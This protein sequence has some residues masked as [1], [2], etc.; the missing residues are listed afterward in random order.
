MSFEL[1]F[2][3]E[4]LPALSFR[5]HM[6]GFLLMKRFFPVYSV[7][8][9]VALAKWLCFLFAYIFLF[10]CDFWRSVIF[11]LRNI[12]LCFTGE[13]IF[14]EASKA[15][16]KLEIFSLESLCPPSV[17]QFP[18]KPFF[19]YFISMI[20]SQASVFCQSCNYLWLGQI[21]S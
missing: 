18:E 21:Q 9:S 16:Q 14:C 2:T 5:S 13:H 12:W 10:E 11:F 3:L 17:T 20:S 19:S 7:K 15:V 4:N 1:F 8:R 6:I